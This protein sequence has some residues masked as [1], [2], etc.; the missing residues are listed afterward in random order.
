[1]PKGHRDFAQ[2]IDIAI[3][4]LELLKMEI[5]AQNVGVKIETEWQIYKGNQKLFYGE[6][7]GLASDAGAYLID[8]TVPAGKVFYVYFATFSSWKATASSTLREGKWWLL[9]DTVYRLQV[10][11]HP[12]TP[13]VGYTWNGPI[14]FDAGDRLRVYVHNS[15]TG[16]GDFACSVH[17]YEVAA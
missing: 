14:R 7:L 2:A 16:A 5:T 9:L 10:Q 11:T 12:Y 17:G 15:G 1:M 3:Q 13:T 6:T 8:Y 4:T